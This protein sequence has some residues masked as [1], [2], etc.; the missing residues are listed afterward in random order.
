MEQKQS[1]GEEEESGEKRK[2]RKKDARRRVYAFL[3][4]EESA[5]KDWINRLDNLHVKAAISPPHNAD[6][7]PD[8]T[9]KKTHWHGLL[10]FDGNKSREQ[11]REILQGV[12]E[13]SFNGHIEDVHDTGA[14]AR[15]LCHLDNPEKARYNPSEVKCLG[16][17]DYEALTVRPADEDE[18]LSEM[19]GYI[20][21]NQIGYFD[22]FVGMC[23]ASN[24]GWFKVCVTRQAFLRGVV[25]SIAARKRDERMR[26]VDPLARVLGGEE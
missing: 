3:A 13:E 26:L 14:Y 17:M 15:Y 18:A 7:L 10:V 1:Q 25:M 20:I 19:V 8:G 22:Q 24:P 12:L 4:Y 6:T 11:V 2:K 5:P 16:G 9:P 21:Q 23:R